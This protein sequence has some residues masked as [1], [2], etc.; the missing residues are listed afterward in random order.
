MG[1]NRQT[2][3]SDAFASLKHSV[4]EALKTYSNVHRGSGHHSL[5]TTHL[6][7]QA[8]DIVLEYLRLDKSRTT[9]IFCTPRRAAVLIAM[10]KPGQY[11][12]ISSQDIG[13]PLGVT[14]LAVN[15]K[16]LPRGTPLETGGGTTRLIAPDW[17]IWAKAPDRFEA[18][19][20]AIVNVIAFARALLL[21]RQSG[22]KVFC[23][24]PTQKRTA[25]EILHNGELEQ[26]TGR[27]LLDALRKTLIG[28]GGVA[29]TTEGDRPYINL[30]NSAS[31]PTFEPVWNAVGQ[32][33]NQPGNI[34]KE[35]V[36]EVRNICAEVLIA[37]LADYDVI[38]TSNTTEAINLA[39]ESLGHESGRDSETGV[40]I[41][42]L[43]HSSNDL[44]WR[45]VS[46][47][48]L[49]RL[50][51]DSDGIINLNELDAHLREYNQENRY[52]EKRIKL[53]AVSGASN[54][55]GVF[56]DLTEIS[57]I[58]HR[59]GARLLVDGAQMVAHRRVD[60]EGWGI[61]YLAF[62]AHKVYAP[63][64]CG[65][66]MVR[67]GLL[68]FSR[69]EMEL[70]RASGEENI[71]GIA[72]LGKA[73]VLLKRI[74]MDVIREEEQKLTARMLRGLAQIPGLTIFGVKDPDLP[75]FDQKGGVI[76]F[77]LKGVMANRVARELSECG[78]IGVR[79]GCHCAH[80]L[81]K[82]LVGVTPLLERFQHFMLT[83]FPGLNL[84]G[85]VRVSMGIENS[86]EDVDTLIRV[87]SQI[88][89]KLRAGKERHSAS[90]HDGISIM[91]QAEVR[92]QLNDCARD[93]ALRVYS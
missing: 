45:K 23:D 62:S 40:L 46:R 10:L 28:S 57:R 39:A 27:Q 29:P 4:R 7:E 91:P 61:D 65:V 90:A 15:K 60:M 31:T 33:W 72:G 77:S 17:V 75:G 16:V 48:P 12:R 88:A 84:P 14:A 82:H 38:F 85:L 71:A 93:A 63:F 67:K 58:V 83:L 5:V 43:E 69:S 22:D 92:K 78:G 50:S 49:I 19:T 3:S 53:V 64:G 76:V 42:L 68:A 32:T 11:Q 34:Q 89:G 54:V 81:V 56:N 37:P 30:D 52:G 35:I 1:M 2:A 24:P 9:V 86:E 73:L 80:I 21:I 74:G 6:Y 55:L 79:S 47:F 13:L 70:I 66:L 25:I 51:I 18:G 44:P 36:Q 8:R 59:Y 26:Y 20:P 87:L 41:T